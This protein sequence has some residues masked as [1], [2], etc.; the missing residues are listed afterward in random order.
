MT[1]PRIEKIDTKILK[2]FADLASR[3]EP[4]SLHC[5]GEISNAEADRKY[6]RLMREWKKLEKQVGRTV[7]EQEIWEWSWNN[8]EEH[9]I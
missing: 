1:Y 5:D 6:R 8:M 9:V 7:T 2:Q 3:L 4:E